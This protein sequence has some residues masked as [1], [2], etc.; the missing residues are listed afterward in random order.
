M[1][2]SNI[3][4]YQGRPLQDLVRDESLVKMLSMDDLANKQQ[5]HNLGDGI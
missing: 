2:A 3:M 5:T 1:I 4:S